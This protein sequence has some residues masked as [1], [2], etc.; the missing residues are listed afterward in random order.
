MRAFVLVLAAGCLAFTS[1]IPQSVAAASPTVAAQQVCTA[2]GGRF[3]PEGTS[4]ACIGDFTA[5]Q[6]TAAAAICV[7]AVGGAAFLPPTDFTHAYVCSV[8]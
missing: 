3:A 4:Y 2:Q 5:S 7:H 6:L 8:G 1:G